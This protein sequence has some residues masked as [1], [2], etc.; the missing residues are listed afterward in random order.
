[1]LYVVL[2]LT[3]ICLTSLYFNYLF[4]DQATDIEIESPSGLLSQSEE[5]ELRKHHD[6]SF[7]ETKEKEPFVK[8]AI[9]EGNAYWVGEDG[10]LWAPM[11]EEQEVEYS[12]QQQVDAHSMNSEEISMMLKILDA[13]KED[14][15]EG[16]ST[17]E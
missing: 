17:G 4:L 13:L 7:R 9:Y 16:G 14:D 11:N 3:L 1:M 12:L 10:L 6:D 15:R 8:I 5:H 2:A